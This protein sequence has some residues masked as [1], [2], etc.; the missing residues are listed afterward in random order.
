MKIINK[1]ISVIAYHTK[2]GAITPMRF[3]MGDDEKVTV[4]VDRVLTK[5]KGKTVGRTYLTFICESIVDGVKRDY[6]LW[7]WQDTQLWVL[8]KM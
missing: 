2:D 6:E 8:Y 3:Q 7:Y 5:S 4:K 1:P